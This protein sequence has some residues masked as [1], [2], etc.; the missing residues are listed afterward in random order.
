MGR[1]SS[2][3]V[4]VRSL[5]ARTTAV[6]AM[7]TDTIQ[8]IRLRSVAQLSQTGLRAVEEI[9]QRTGFSRAKVRR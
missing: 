8:R 3:D 5:G 2:L 9:A 4:I 7:L 6:P 1:A